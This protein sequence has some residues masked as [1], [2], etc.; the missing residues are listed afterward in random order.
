MI[1]VEGEAK[2]NGG[3][4]EEQIIEEEQTATKR[5]PDRLKSFQTQKATSEEVA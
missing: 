2:G 1:G 5:Q 3:W 4:K